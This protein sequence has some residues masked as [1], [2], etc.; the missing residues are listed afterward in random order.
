MRLTKDVKRAAMAAVLA[1]MFAGAAPAKADDP[2]VSSAG[3][4]EV[5]VRATSLRVRGEV[6]ATGKD[7][8]AALEAL[9]K[10]KAAVSQGLEALKPASGTLTIGDA[11]VGS[12]LAEDGSGESAY[13]QM[14]M[15]RRQPK[16]PTT[17]VSVSALVKLS[18]DLPAGEPDAVLVG[19][20]QLEDKVKAVLKSDA[21]PAALTPE[22]KEQ[23]E[24]MQAMMQAGGPS[25][26]GITF[27]YVA[28][29]GDDALRNA[30][31][32]AITKARADAER[33]ARAAGLELGPMKRLASSAESEM[34]S[35]MQR[36]SRMQM[37][38]S[39]EAD[40]NEAVGSA[41]G[42]LTLEVTVS[43]TYGLI[44]K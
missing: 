5:K 22:Q 29:V 11:V 26:E 13:A 6:T 34:M 39:M 42:K 17:D 35:Y 38:K 41:P 31:A 32:E 19:A 44:A 43:T 21:A 1:G 30:T 4:A 40:K 16:Q 36:M 7:L 25:A 18:L 37:G 33:L 24:E 23:M 28:P 10:R 12:A 3:S 2:T 20:K 27:Q 8:G 14:M 9:A 15:G